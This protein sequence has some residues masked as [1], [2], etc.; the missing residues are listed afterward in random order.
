MFLGVPFN[1]AST[2]CLVYIM[3]HLTNCTP[4]KIILNIL[5]AISPVGHTTETLK[6]LVFDIM[7]EHY[8]KNNKS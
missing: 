5:P 2:S 3:A 6:K 8:K 7:A 4:G 1:I